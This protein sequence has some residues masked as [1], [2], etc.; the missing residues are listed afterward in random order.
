MSH[1]DIFGDSALASRLESFDVHWRRA[2]SHDWHLVTQL[3]GS[4]LY[5][6][7]L[8]TCADTVTD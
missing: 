8:C 7:T 2:Y 4:L 1:Y 3:R 5:S 6:V